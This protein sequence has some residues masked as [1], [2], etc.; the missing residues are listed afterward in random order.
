MIAPTSNQKQLKRIYDLMSDGN[1]RTAEEISNFTGD[2]KTSVTSRLRDLRLNKYGGHT[3][4]ARN[5]GQPK[6]WTYKLDLGI[7]NLAPTL[8]STTGQ[9]TTQGW[10]PAYVP[11]TKNVKFLN[12]INN[13]VEYIPETQCRTEP[14]GNSTR[15]VAL[16]SK[17][18]I[19]EHLITTQEIL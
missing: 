5:T 14:L 8:P 17:N 10:R 19:I 4:R 16:D 1:W 6:V 2:S 12:L 13:K 7:S 9:P 3:V 18:N 11:T 15:V